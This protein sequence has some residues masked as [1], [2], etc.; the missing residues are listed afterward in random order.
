VTLPH[1]VDGDGPPIVLLHAGVA[2]H[3]TWEP[4]VRLLSDRHRVVRYDLRGFGEAGPE[5]AEY[6][7]S[8]DLA[9]LLEALEIDRTALIGCSNGGRVALQLAIERPER[10]SDLTLI[11]AP[12][13]GHDFGDDVVAA[14]EEAGA[15]LEAGDLDAAVDADLRAW[16][17]GPLRSLDEVDA[18]VR[19]LAT[20]M[21]RR[22][23]ELYLA[24]TAEE[25]P[26]DPPLAE[27]LGAVTAQTLVVDAE[28]DF[29]D[30]AA[31]ADRIAAGV[32]DSRR[33]TIEGAAHLSPLERPEAVAALLG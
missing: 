13:P 15:A 20:D 19:M 10:V 12:L 5:D 6:S 14:W 9:E 18:G 32:P 7:A 33:A 23:A 24:A 25:R 26:A 31:M 22:A 30:F 17:A 1:W 27:R 2:D 29:P 3:R 4:L 8:D 28:L 16:V 21:A 11:S